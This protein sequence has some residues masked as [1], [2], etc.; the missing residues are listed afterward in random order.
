[1]GREKVNIFGIQVDRITNKEVLE[2]IELFL[3]SA[4]GHWIVTFNSEMAVRAKEDSAFK[5]V[6]NSADLVTADGVGILRAASFLAEKKHNF[7]SDFKILFLTT[8]YAV[9]HPSKIKNVLP[10][11]ISG[12][13]LIFD[14]CAS[15]FIKGK[16][17]C[18]VGGMKQAASQ[19]K[20][21]LE[22]KFSGIEIVCIGEGI[23]PEQNQTLA[24]EVNALSPDIL[25]VAF[26]APKQEEWI[27]E[28]LS[29]MPTVKVAIG[30][31]G[32]FDVISGRIKRAPKF[33][34]KHGL[35]WLWRFILQPRRI[36]RIYNATIK[37]SW[38]IFTDK[39]GTI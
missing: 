8:L 4:S 1:M 26:G 33:F 20:E 15:D 17:I 18:F 11:K 5:K 2:S 34:Q 37:M 14:I 27:S 36:K 23:S 13:D 12:I 32:S 16:K 6:I 38:L 30:I 19:A 39:K 9:C 24:E 10:E 35:E 21:N 22:R 29:K 7:F 28:N 31:G 3:C 25:F